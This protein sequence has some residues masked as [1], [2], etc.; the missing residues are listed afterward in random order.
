M[1]VYFN[2]KK[3]SLDNLDNDNLDFNVTSTETVISDQSNYSV[4]INRFKIPVG[5]VDFF[6]LYPNR[7]QLGVIFNTSFPKT[8]ARIRKNYLVDLFSANNC[9]ILTDVD[10]DNIAV[11]NSRVEAQNRF[12]VVDSNEHFCRILNRALASSF[13]TSLE[14]GTTFY[15]Y[16]YVN[17]NGNNINYPTKIATN[18][19]YHYYDVELDVNSGTPRQLG[20]ITFPIVVPGSDPAQNSLNE[21]IVDLGVMINLNAVDLSNG[22]ETITGDDNFKDSP[23]TKDTRFGDY[24]FTIKV[25]NSLLSPA[26]TG[27]NVVNFEIPLFSNVAKNLTW[28][29]VKQRFPNGIKYTMSDE[30]GDVGNKY[31]VVNH[32]LSY[33]PETNGSNGYK[34]KIIQPLNQ[35]D[36]THLMG[37]NVKGFNFTLYMTYTGDGILDRSDDALKPRFRFLGVD[38]QGGSHQNSNNNKWWRQGL[39]FYM[40]TSRDTIFDASYSSTAGGEIQSFPM[41]EF[42]DTTQKIELRIQRDY[43][44]NRNFAI[45]I[46][47]G[48]YNLMG[49]DV[50]NKKQPL[51]HTYPYW[52][53]YYDPSLDSGDAVLTLNSIQDGYLLRINDVSPSQNYQSSDLY[54]TVPE[55]QNSV[56]KRNYLYGLSILSP[57]L[58]ITGEFVGNGKSKRRILTD[59]VI[60]PSINFRDYLIYNPEGGQRYYQLNSGT[61]LREILV[62]VYIVDM[63]NNLKRLTLP[64]GTSASMKLEF[65]P[66]NE[67]QNYS[68]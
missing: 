22:T 29:E 40:A 46:N 54:L 25:D 68:T 44:R 10:N 49:F 17:N 26:P 35:V 57:S 16:S 67:I 51:L 59:F 19:N 31:S 21:F 2:L 20:K 32:N 53:N 28:G 62:A 34:G 58:A 7:Y 27:D 52:G 56:F 13:N 11:T 41:F 48:L 6:R 45:F 30:V 12:N 65:K 8:D 4:G 18:P 23:A 15:E 36:L 38:D 1:S 50:T 47:K 64:M 43:V 60:D 3:D 37:R 63:N 55:Q 33:D 14:G 42:N 61:A 24:Q 66:N 39:S 5:D 9:D